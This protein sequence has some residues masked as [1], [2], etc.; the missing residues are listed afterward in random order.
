MNPAELPRDFL[1]LAM[2]VLL[3]GVKH[4]F[5][6]DH[7]AAIDGLTRYNAAAR[8]R[9]ARLAGVLFS[10][11]HGLVVV[12]VALG[13]S[14][15]ARA[16]Q[17]PPWLESLGAWM[18]I[19]VLTLLALMN[20]AAVFRTPRHEMTALVGWRCGLFS[21]LLASSSPAMVMGVGTLFAI[22]FD[23]VSQAA[24]FGMA[25]TQFGGW[26]PALLLALVFISGM[27]VTD[28]LNGWWIARLV[29]RADHTARIASRV[30]ALAISGVGL[31]I[32]ATAV[33][34]RTLPAV[35]AW[36]EGKELWFG[37]AVVAVVLAS[38]AIGQQLAGGEPASA[39]HLGST[40]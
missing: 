13:V 38:Y 32:A 16:W 31:L 36:T 18:S 15:L 34:S 12:A 4:G 26:Q 20:I 39:K 37:A 24:L 23:T 14:Q 11:G 10:L 27:L 30:L 1:G 8:P 29:R 40:R 28:G 21:R 3:L 5:D 17:A 7:L 35:D 22:S 33:A 2:V 6:A 25:A 9:L 19:A